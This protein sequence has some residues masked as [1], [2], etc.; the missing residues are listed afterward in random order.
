M[1]RFYGRVKGGRGT[2]TRQGH[3]TTGLWTHVSGWNMGIEISLHVD[4]YDNDVAMIYVTKGSGSPD[5]K[6]LLA[7]VVDM[8]SEARLKLENSE[9]MD[10]D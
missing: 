8:D 2:V 7:E 10:N 4:D 6:K 5:N 9:F 1:S 3:K